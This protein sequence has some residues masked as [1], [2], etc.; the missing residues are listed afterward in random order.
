MI[1]YT[2]IH[3]SFN[4]AELQLIKNA[5]TNHD[6]DYRVLNEMLLQVGN[7]EV[8]GYNGARVQ[9]DSLKVGQAKRLLHELNLVGSD[10]TLEGEDT[11]L[12]P[13]LRLTERIPLLNLLDPVFQFL[14][15]VLLGAILLF[16]MLFWLG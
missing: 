14:G 10:Q 4:I 8:M 3:E 13:V 1:T 5:L 11:F 2:E 15:L 9:V 16:A 7:A 12:M 6:I